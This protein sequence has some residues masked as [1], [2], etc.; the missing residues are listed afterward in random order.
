MVLKLELS[1]TARCAS[2]SELT[3]QKAKNSFHKGALDLKI[4]MQISPPNEY[5]C[6]Q[7]KYKKKIAQEDI[8]KD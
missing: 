2:H 7:P 3:R 5:K 1:S 6:C 4:Q 8:R